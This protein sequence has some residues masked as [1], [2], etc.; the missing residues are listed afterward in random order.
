MNISEMAMP[1]KPIAR[2]RRLPSSLPDLAAAAE[3]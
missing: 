2:A 1:T 3:A